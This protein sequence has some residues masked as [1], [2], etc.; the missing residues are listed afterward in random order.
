MLEKLPYNQVCNRSPGPLFTVQ[1]R[2][3]QA[4]DWR[5]SPL[6]RHPVTAGP[7]APRPAWDDHPMFGSLIIGSAD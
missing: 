3:R 4:R 2:T 1:V 5:L 7:G 6:R